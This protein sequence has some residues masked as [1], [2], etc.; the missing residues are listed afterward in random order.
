MHT[1]WSKQHKRVF[2]HCKYSLSNSFGEPLT[3]P[4]LQAYTQAR[5][6]TALLQAYQEHGLGYTPNGG[7]LDLKQDIANLYDDTI[8]PQHILV[9]PGAQVALATACRVL[10]SEGHSIVFGPGYQSTVES[11]LIQGKNARMTILERRPENGWQISISQV[12]QAIQPDTK[13]ILLNEPYNPAGTLMSRQTQQEL[14]QLAQKHHIRILCDEVYRLLEHNPNDRIPAMCEALPGLGLSVVT[15]SKPWGGCGIS[16]GWIACSSAEMMD[17][18]TDV[19]YFGTACPSRASELQAMMVLRASDAILERNLAII[20]Q[21]LLLWDG[22][23]QRYEEWFD[24][25]RPTA[26]AIGFVRFKGP[27]T[28]AELGEQLAAEKQ[29]SMKPSYCFTANQEDLG[30]FRV[31][32]GESKMPKALGV[33]IAFVEEHQ[34]AWREA[35][36]HQEI[37]ND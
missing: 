34:E 2:R 26:G 20:R 33:L 10:S 14:V 31:G 22:F 29:L 16:I 6:D 19:Q 15:L 18:L 37:V 1:P 7:S 27:M 25:V 5:G 17:Q 8:Q 23:M 12:E 3:Q 24:W 32:F 36:R 28:S 35:K 21:N 30:Y 9:F 13:F 4:Q 11:P